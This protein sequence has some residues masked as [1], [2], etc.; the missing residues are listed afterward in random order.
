MDEQD[1]EY[2]EA[3]AKDVKLDDITSSQQNADIL[4]RLRDDDPD[5]TYISITDE[6]YD[7]SDLF[8]REGDNLGWLG[9]FFGRSKQVKELYIYDLPDNLKMD[10]FFGGLGHNRSIQQLYIYTDLG[11]SLQ[12]LG[13]LLR[14]NGSLRDLTFSGF[15]IGLQCARNIGSMLGQQC[16]LKC[17]NFEETNLGDETFVEIATALSK[18]PQIEELNLSTSNI[19]RN[20]CVALG[21]ALDGM[22]NPNLATLD[23]GYNDID[24]E[25]LHA[26]VAGLINCHNLTS[27]YLHGNELITG[28]GL[29]SLSTLLQ[30]DN[31][32]LEHLDV[33][34]TNM[35]NDG[36]VVLSAGLSRLPTLKKLDL[37]NNRIGDL[38]LQ[39]LVGGLGSCNLLEE[40]YLSSNMFLGSIIGMR[41]LGTLLQRTNMQSLFLSDAVN[42][43][44]LQCLVDGMANCCRLKTL[45]LSYNNSITAV[46]LRSLSSLFRSERCSL[47]NLLLLHLDDNGAVALADGLIGNK[48]LKT[49]EFSRSG[50]TERGWSAFSKLLCDTSSVNNTYLSNHTL[51]KIGGYGVHAMPSDDIV[52]YLQLNRVSQKNAAIRK[53]LDSHP[54]I[55]FEPLFQWKLK[56]L[57]LVV[58]WLENAKRYLDYVKESNEV[59]QR[60]QVSAVYK[61]VRGMPLLTVDGYRGQK[62]TDTQSKKRK[63][64][65]TS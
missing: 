26:L 55:D 53:I 34:R 21:N 44:G 56:F 35:D 2:Y 7:G 42:D 20:G 38:G 57:P 16:S 4:E 46:G 8:L 30:S 33:E 28:V 39:A 12:S 6:T 1:Y 54:D 43:G 51:E 29:R 36:V 45:A 50:I 24:D 64:D 59:F 31:C 23:L 13:P 52:E 14:N 10:E 11:E 37:A 18:Q 40:L 60:R 32:C 47:C 41:S 5:F 63:F 25:D 15:N 49:V 61:F 62:M 65:Q 19:G 48:S 9:Y 27:L 58:T 22:R 17:L 3:R